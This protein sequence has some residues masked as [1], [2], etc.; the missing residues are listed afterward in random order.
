MIIPAAAS[1]CPRRKRSNAAPEREQ[2]SICPVS[3]THLSM[4]DIRILAIETSCDETAAAVVKNGRE[5][6]SEALY[7]QIEIH[8]EYGGGVPELASRNHVEKLPGVVEAAVRA[9]GGFDEIDAIAVTNGPGLVGALLTGC[10]LY[11]SRCV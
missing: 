8:K 7:T 11:T 1:P 6:I 9:A 5:I 3:Y 10:L 4:E 2:L